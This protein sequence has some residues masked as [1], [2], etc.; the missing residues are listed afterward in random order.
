MESAGRLHPPRDGSFTP[1]KPVRR[2]RKRFRT[3]TQFEREAE[4]AGYVST[5]PPPSG[6]DANDVD[7]AR[8]EA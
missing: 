2:N 5:D 6:I 1:L 8:F 7:A 3:N 4:R